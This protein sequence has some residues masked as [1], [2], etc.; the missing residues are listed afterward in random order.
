MWEAALQAQRSVEA[1]LDE[2]RKARSRARVI[3]LKSQVEALRTHADL[4]LAEAVKVKC[5]FRDHNMNGVW[6]ATTQPGSTE[7]GAR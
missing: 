6:A 1:E 7:E 5:T 4:L 3:Q 2:A